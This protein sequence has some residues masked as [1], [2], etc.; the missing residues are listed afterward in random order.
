MCAS[1]SGGS[2]FFSLSTHQSS[3]P[4]QH[5]QLKEVFFLRCDRPEDLRENPMWLAVTLPFF[6]EAIYP[7][8]TYKKKWDGLLFF[9]FSHGK[10]GAGECMAGFRNITWTIFLP[11]STEGH[12]DRACA[13]SFSYGWVRK[14]ATFLTVDFSPIRRKAHPF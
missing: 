6:A 14:T 13:P 7:L 10:D 8:L 1:S 12:A 3:T 4:L 2:H 9:P 11:S 5:K